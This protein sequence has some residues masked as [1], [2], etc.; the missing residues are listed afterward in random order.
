M[1]NINITNTTTTGVVS[2]IMNLVVY[3]TISILLK[4]SLTHVHTFQILFLLNLSGLAVTSAIFILKGNNVFKT[5]YIDRFYLSRGIIYTLGIITWVYALSMIPITD[6]TS[7]SY[8]TPLIA[9][10]IGIFLFKE[11]LNKQ[12][13]I[14]TLLGVLGM[15][16]ILKPFKSTLSTQGVSF[17]FLSALLWAV[18]DVLV[19]VQSKR[20][21]WLK[22]A[23]IIFMLVSILSLPLSISVW[24]PIDL[25]YIIICL[26][27]GV[28][29]I[30]NKFFLIHALS[31]VPLVLL[32][33]VSFFRLVFTSAIAYILFNEILDF[34]SVIG[35]IIILYSTSIAVS[36]SRKGEN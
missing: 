34:Y 14:A 6:A 21:H 24:Q 16:I 18:H 2:K 23:H 12:I 1:V 27:I 22:Q 29:S 25:K 8:A 19:K 15:V 28:L 35:V 30:I 11:V 5:S 3:S 31:K 13:I 4:I 32:S 36:I 7:I 33:P 9:A 17:A 20:E 26:G 10:L